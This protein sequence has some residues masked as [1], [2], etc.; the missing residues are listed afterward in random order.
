M[1]TFSIRVTS[2]GPDELWLACFADGSEEPEEMIV[3]VEAR[4]TWEFLGEHVEHHYGQH[5]CSGS[6]AMRVHRGCGGYIRSELDG[7][8]RCYAA[9]HSGEAGLVSREDTAVVRIPLA[10]PAGA[11]S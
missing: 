1:T 2:N 5:G 9:G 10:R 3:Q 4:D 11:P 6:Y 8:L 7:T